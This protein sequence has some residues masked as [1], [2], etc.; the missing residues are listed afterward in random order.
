VGKTASDTHTTIVDKPTDR[1]P[2]LFIHANC[3]TIEIDVKYILQ[4]ITCKIL[5]LVYIQ[6]DIE[7]WYG[8]ATLN[9]FVILLTHD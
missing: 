4:F 1:F 8:C 7:D 3:I 5:C 9:L 2:N 6:K